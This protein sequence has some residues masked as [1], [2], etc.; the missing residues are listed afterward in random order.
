MLLP[1]PASTGMSGAISLEDMPG[2]HNLQLEEC[3]QLCPVDYFAAAVARRRP[4]PRRARGDGG[5]LVRG[6]CAW[7]ALCTYLL[8]AELAVPVL[9]CRY[10]STQSSSSN[11]Y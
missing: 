10:L 8:Y 5:C 7:S 9:L 3:L 6:S 4:D 1:S 2:A 11:T